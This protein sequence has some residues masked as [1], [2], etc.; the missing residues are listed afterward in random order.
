[1]EY[2]PVRQE[3]LEGILA[4]YDLEDWTSYTDNRDLAWQAFN[5]PGTCTIVAMEDG[6]VVGFAQMQSDG[7]IQAHLSL[8]A[9][10]PSHRRKGIGR[11]LVNY[12]FQCS[13]GS[14]LI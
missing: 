2:R 8:I 13:G 7:V 14:G 9:V 4:S 11:K 12:S 6:K 1:M 10:A 5:A 3:D